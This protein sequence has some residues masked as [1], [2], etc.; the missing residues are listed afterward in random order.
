M[1]CVRAS[2]GAQNV[3]IRIKI[4]STPHEPR[5]LDL[6]VWMEESTPQGD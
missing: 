1:G 4:P 6:D 5:P 2:H 3:G